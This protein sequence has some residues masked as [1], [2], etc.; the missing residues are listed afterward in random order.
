MPNKRS[1]DKKLVN[2]WFTHNEAENLAKAASN[3]GLSMTDFVKMA[4]SELIHKEQI[5]EHKNRKRGS[6]DN[7]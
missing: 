7:G 5:N 6:G 3:L 4:I 1:D 2:F